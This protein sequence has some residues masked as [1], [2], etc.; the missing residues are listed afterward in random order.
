MTLF[1]QMTNIPSMK[2]I[3]LA[4]SGLSPQILTESLY[5]LA[6]QRPGGVFIPDEIHLITTLEG[7]SRARLLLLSDAPGWYHR[8][9]KEYG[10][11]DCGFS[12]DHIHVLKNA[13]G[14]PMDDIRTPQDNGEAADYIIRMVRDLTEQDD[15]MIHASIAGGRKT[16]GFYLGYA[17]SLFGRSQD[18]LSHVLVS[19]PY[20]SL[21]DFFYPSMHKR[22]IFA[23]DNQ[24][25]LDTSQAEVWLA[26]IPFVRM[27]FGMP[28][29]I[30]KGKVNF[31]DA[32]AA[33][34]RSFVA[35][36]LSIDASAMHIVTAIGTVALP[37]VDMAFYL[38]LAQHRINSDGQVYCPPDG[39]PDQA[40]GKAYFD[41]YQRLTN[42]GLRGHDRTREALRKGMTKTYF[43]QRKSLINKAIRMGLGVHASP[44][45][46][47]RTGT[48]GHYTFGLLKLQAS[49]IA[50]LPSSLQ[51]LSLQPAC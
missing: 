14:E 15:T 10:L 1:A 3:L 36:S 29:A 6:V 8:L 30:L 50:I 46:I 45:E 28:E 48:P 20:E 12:E 4:V 32:V 17:M 16:M 44:Y 40:C 18:E 23:R 49:Q 31:S 22:I 34:S 19:P 7:A 37:P 41:I 39:C 2:K 38:W 24:K 9:C 43:E 5:A 47:V 11:P 13:Q 35:P 21:K 51:S 25:P 27:R 26:S 33:A 42:N